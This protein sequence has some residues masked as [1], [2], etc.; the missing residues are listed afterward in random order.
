MNFYQMDIKMSEY[1]L[2]FKSDGSTECKELIN[3]FIEGVNKGL[4]VRKNIILSFT[5]FDKDQTIKLSETV[6]QKK[7]LQ[8]KKYLI[9]S[10]KIC[11][12]SKEITPDHKYP[13]IKKR[14]ISLEFIAG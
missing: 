11:I 4:Y 8:F 6:E 12:I 1:D 9:D 14:R 7:Y 10:S 5:L 13:G 3:F 2:L